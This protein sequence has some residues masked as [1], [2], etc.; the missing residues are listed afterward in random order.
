M[1]TDRLIVTIPPLDIRESVPVDV[2]RLS[3]DTTLVTRVPLVV[4]IVIVGVPAFACVDIVAFPEVAPLITRFVNFPLF[5]AVEPIGGGDAKS[6]VNPAPLTVPDD[7]RVANDAG[8]PLPRSVVNK[9]VNPEPLMAPDAERVVNAPLL[10]DAEPIGGG[11][12]KRFVNP[13]PLTAPLAAR[14]VNEAAPPLVPPN[15][16]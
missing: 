10:G 3:G 13:V 6:D 14:V 9:L 2:L 16:N 4:G 8:K 11:A 1:N 7:W 12:A 15:P 5:G